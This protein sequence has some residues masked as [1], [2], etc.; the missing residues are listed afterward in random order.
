MNILFTVD[1]H[2]LRENPWGYHAVTTELCTTCQKFRLHLPVWNGLKPRVVV[3][4]H[5]VVGTNAPYVATLPESVVSALSEFSVRWDDAAIAA[6]CDLMRGEGELAE[7]YWDILEWLT[8][9][10][11]ADGFAYW[12]SNNTIKKFCKANSLLSVAME[13]GPTRSPFMETRYC[14]FMGV[15]GDAMTRGMDL[16]LFR[17]LNLERWRRLEGIR[18]QDGRRQDALFT[19]LTT[20]WASKIYRNDKPLALLILQ[21][22]DDSNCLI[23]SEYSG[24][25]EMVREVVPKLVSAGWQ[26]LVKPHPGAAPGMNIRKNRQQNVIGHAMAR[27]FVENNY[28]DGEAVWLDD[29]PANEYISLLGKIDVAI[30]VNS[31]MCFEAML[32][33]KIAVALGNA[34][35]NVT[36]GLPTL[37]DVLE[38]RVDRQGYEDYAARVATLMLKYYLYPHQLLESPSMLSSAI[39]RNKMLDEAYDRGG[40]DALSRVVRD[41]PVGIVSDEDFLR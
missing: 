3:T 37:D 8:N 1:L 13:L 25:N 23:H 21:L 24:M 2:T 39:F 40:Y 10:Y 36:D 19:P 17:P 41:N 12:G 29:V 38:G 20:R 15:N 31:S 4:K 16:S 18:Y 33:G 35:Y 11:G 30:S 27:A 26:V 6:W 7:L 22:D 32:S 14:D 28:P 9:K 34:P 5:E